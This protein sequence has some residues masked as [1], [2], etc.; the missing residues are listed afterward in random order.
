MTTDPNPEACAPD[1]FMSALLNT[2]AQPSDPN[3][4]APGIR[5]LPNKGGDAKCDTNSQQP[6]R[7]SAETQ[8]ASMAVVSSNAAPTSDPLAAASIRVRVAER[9]GYSNFYQGADNGLL[10]A[11]LPGYEGACCRVPDYL[12]SVDAAM[13]CVREAAKDKWMCTLILDPD[14]GSAYC[15]FNKGAQD[16]HAKHDNPAT[17]ICLAFLAT[18]GR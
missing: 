5:D 11:D 3:P 14:D 17:A 7:A 16:V 9:F 1:V 15:A 8:G 12:N 6:E 4:D 2:D 18:P 13:A 10:V